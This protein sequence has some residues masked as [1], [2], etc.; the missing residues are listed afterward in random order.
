MSMRICAT[1]GSVEN[2]GNIDGVNVCCFCLTNH[3]DFSSLNDADMAIYMGIAYGTST[4]L[5]Y[6]DVDTKSIEGAVFLEIC[7]DILGAD[8][9]IMW[10]KGNKYIFEK[11]RLTVDDENS[12]CFIISKVKGE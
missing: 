4:L 6:V 1:C 12:T 5:G 3:Y 9:F 10:L 8:T 2:V 7:D 11:H